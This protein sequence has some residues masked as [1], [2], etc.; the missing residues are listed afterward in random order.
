MHSPEVL[1]RTSSS[2][3]NTSPC[4]ISIGLDDD[5]H[6]SQLGF[7]F[8]VA[9]ALWHDI[10]ACATTGRVPRMPYRQWLEGTGL[11]MATLMGCYNWVMVAIGDLAHLQA[12]KKEMR[13]QER[14]SVP[15]LVRKGQRIEKRLQDG[16]TELKQ[17]VKVSTNN[18]PK[19]RCHMANNS[20]FH[21]WEAIF[22]AI[23]SQRHGSHTFLQLH[24]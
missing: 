10:L 1:L 16:I 5:P 6:Q 4:P 17:T 23:C 2:P 24:H 9:E 15:E 3:G 11:E 20:Y 21:R 19:P 14:L 22:E 18:I 12:W 8:L 7:D 13:Q